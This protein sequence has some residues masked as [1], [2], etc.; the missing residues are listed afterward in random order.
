MIGV[1]LAAGKGSRL[2]DLTNETPKSL[3]RLNKNMTLLDYN[4]IMLKKLKVK[5]ILIITGFESVQI[6]E[7]VSKMPNVKC[8]FNPFWNHCN[9]LG[10]L[11]M[12]LP[13]INDDFFFLHADTLVDF[14]IWSRINNMKADV[15]LPYQR[16]VCG[17]EEMKVRH[18][19]EGN[20]K[21]ISKLIDPIQ[22]DGEFIG[23]AKFNQSFVKHMKRFA[24]KLFKAG[25]LNL[26]M[27]SIIEEAIKE[28]TIITT[29]D[30]LEASFVEVDFIEDYRFAVKQFSNF[31]K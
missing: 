17:E 22:A 11:Y 4:L 6:E 18:D 9:V 8:I 23:V 24:D 29:F 26:Y 7:H 15:V 1:I 21:E 30:I 5:E 31:K 19:S 3:L 16:K 14:S 28:N 10:S 12:G 25:F 20:L 2:G 27:E 13:Y